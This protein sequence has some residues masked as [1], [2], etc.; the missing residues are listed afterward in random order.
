[1]YLVVGELCVQGGKHMKCFT[2]ITEF[3]NTFN[4]KISIVGKCWCQVVVHKLSFTKLLCK[5]SPYTCTC[6]RCYSLVRMSA[7]ICMY[8]YDSTEGGP[9]V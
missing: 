3:L 4:R 1:M 6:K 2:L 8:V 7:G 9:L 5:T